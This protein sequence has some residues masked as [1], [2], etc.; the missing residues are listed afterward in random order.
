MGDQ[1]R[2]GTVLCLQPHF[3]GIQ[4]REDPTWQVQ[5]GNRDVSITGRVNLQCHF[6]AGTPLKMRGEVAEWHR[7]PR[8]KGPLQCQLHPRGGAG[9]SDVCCEHLD[10]HGCDRCSRGAGGQGEGASTGNALAACKLQN[11]PSKTRTQCDV[12]ACKLQTG[13]TQIIAVHA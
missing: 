10:A 9:P 1:E 7:A 5:T 3:W 12:H 8:A 4:S 11:L 6:V 13:K 2:L